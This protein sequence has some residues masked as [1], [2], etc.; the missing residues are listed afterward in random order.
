LNYEE[1]PCLY[2]ISS[3]FLTPIFSLMKQSSR[4]L[5]IRRVLANLCW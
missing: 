5:E 3:Y 2:I 1:L 4:T